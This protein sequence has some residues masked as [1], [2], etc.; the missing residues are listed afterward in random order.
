MPFAKVPVLALNILSHFVSYDRLHPT[1]RT[2]ALT[3]SSESLPKSYVE[4]LQVPP[5]KEAMDA[6]IAALLARGTW[7]L[8]H[9]PRDANIVTCKWVFTIKYN[10]DGTIS[11]HKARLVAR[12]FTQAYDIDYTETFS[13]VV[14]LNSIRVLLSLAVNQDWSLHQ[15]DV[16][17]AFLYGDLDEQVFMEQPPGYVAQGESSKVCRL[18]K[19]IYG[20]KQSPRA[21]FVK[22]VAFSLPLAS[23]RVL[24]IPLSSSNR[25]PQ[26]MVVLAVY[27]DDILL[28]GSDEAGINATKDYLQSHLDTRDMGTPRYFLGIEFAYQSGKLALSQRKYALDLL[29]ETGLLGCKPATSP[30]EARSQFWDDTSPL[31]ED[32]NRY[33]RLLGKLI[34]LTVT[35]PDI[36]Y[37]VS[38]LSQFMQEPRQVHW[39]GA[40]RVLAYIKN[41]PGRGLIY[42]RHGHTRVEA[43]SDAGYAGDK[44]DRKSTTGYC[45]YV[46]GNLVTWRSRKQKVVSCSSAEAEYRAMAETAREM[47]W[48]KSLLTNLGITTSAPMPMHCDNQA[49][50]F[51]ASNA[52]FHERT[53]HIETDCHYIRDKVVTGEISTPHVPSASQLAD[54]FTKGLAGVSYDSFCTKLGLTDIYAPA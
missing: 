30:M 31:L 8:V 42:R 45:T 48:I 24:L 2:F 15:L 33:R 28:T 7:A 11:R 26:G 44:G 52:T 25:R 22:F 49:A 10:P 39:E 4:A 13:P 53:K 21:W 38:L 29:Q 17:N 6:E 46:G 47:I 23:L 41:A 18:R 32:A 36:V 40:L 12:G 54:I 50:I 27:V 37:T 9:R 16:S 19:A 20:L 5:W 3:I 14:R 43:Y 1:F 35:R 34:Y 51:I